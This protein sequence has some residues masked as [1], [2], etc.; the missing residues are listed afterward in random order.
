MARRLLG[1]AGT[2][3]VHFA[4]LPSFA[5]CTIPG[6]IPQPKKRPQRGDTRLGPLGANYC[7]GRSMRSGPSTTGATLARSLFTK[8]AAFWINPF[9]VDNLGG[10]TLTH[11]VIPFKSTGAGQIKSLVAGRS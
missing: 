3:G 4:G 2:L 7:A 9:G 8:G 11:Y 5:R 10:E 6:M 1:E